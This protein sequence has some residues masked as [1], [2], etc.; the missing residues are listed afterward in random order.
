MKMKAYVAAIM[1]GIF[2]T[3]I[4]SAQELMIY[5]AKGQSVKQMEII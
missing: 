2:V 4:A 1:A 5:P 3:G